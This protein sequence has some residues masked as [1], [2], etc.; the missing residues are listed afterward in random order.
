[1]EDPYQN[2]PFSVLIVERHVALAKPIF[3]CLDY[4]SPPPEIRGGLSA[5]PCKSTTRAIAEQEETGGLQACGPAEGLQLGGAVPFPQSL[6]IWK[7]W[8]R[9]ASLLQ[10]GLLLPRHEW[11][12]H[13]PG[14]SRERVGLEPGELGALDS[15]W[16]TLCIICNWDRP[17]AIFMMATFQDKMREGPSHLR[18]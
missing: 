1:M 2:P 7:I 6:T 8:A 11:D 10:A 16:V 15:R 18:A 5:L 12:R 14:P 9:P 3:F 17:S 4:Q 13:T